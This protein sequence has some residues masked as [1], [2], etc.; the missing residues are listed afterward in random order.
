MP[1]EQRLLGRPG[2]LLRGV[3]RKACG[4]PEK[5]GAL[6][7]VHL[8]EVA[9][10]LAELGGF[11]LGVPPK[12][13]V[14]FA[15]ELA[16]LGRLVTLVHDFVQR[17][18]ESARPLLER[19]DGRNGVT[20]LDAGDVATQKARSFFDVALAEVF[21]FAKSSESLTDLHSETSV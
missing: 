17:H 5:D 16:R 14:I 7:L 3:T 19:F 6:F 4:E 11:L 13:L 2:G 10:Q 15:N 20:V 18:V 21:F 8:G 12:A 1:R 9:L